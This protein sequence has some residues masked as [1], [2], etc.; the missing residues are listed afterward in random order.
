MIEDGFPPAGYLGFKAV[1]DGSGPV[2]IL[3]LRRELAATEQDWIDRL[4]R[5]LDEFDTV[6]RSPS[7]PALLP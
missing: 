2:V 5:A 4:H 7:R 3:F 1:G 6:S